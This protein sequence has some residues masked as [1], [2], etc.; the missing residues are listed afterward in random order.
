MRAPIPCRGE[1]WLVDLSPNRGHEQS[2]RRPCLIMSTDLFNHGPAGLAIVIPLTT[3][4]KRI[5]L[6]VPLESHE[7]GLHERSFI[8]CED[9]RSVASERLQHRIG[10]APP[11]TI[12]QVADR[13]RILLEL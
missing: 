7:S 13:V 1:L 10:K 12:E 11:A 3:R 8:K 2:G 5:P 9:L 4:D 6:H